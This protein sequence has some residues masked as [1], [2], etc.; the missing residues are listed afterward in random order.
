MGDVFDAFTRLESSRNRETGGIGLGLALARAHGLRLS[1]PVRLV[2][3]GAGLAALAAAGEPDALWRPVAYGGPALLLVA[4]AALGRG[5]V[6]RGRDTGGWAMRAIVALGDASY[7]LYLTHPFVLRGTREAVT[8][9][10]LAGVLGPWGLLAV[11]LVLAAAAA[12]VVARLVEAPL[13]RAVRRRLDPRPRQKPCAPGP[14]AVCRR[15]KSL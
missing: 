1:V 3:A 10:G 14:A 11:M 8:R 13:T 6:A 2:L 15:G 5:T 7:A 4:A 9:L 12:L